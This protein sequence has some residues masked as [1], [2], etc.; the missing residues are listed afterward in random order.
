MKKVASLKLDGIRANGERI[1]VEF[2]VGEPYLK[3]IGPPEQWRCPVQVAP[4]DH[5][6]PD[7]AGADSIQALTLALR[8][9]F[10]RLQ[11]FVDHGGKLLH[12]DGT[13]FRVPRDAI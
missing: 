11:S 12:D 8:L 1:Q 13:E 9:G 4:I 7:I 6:L 3:V 5:Y 10:S 2:S